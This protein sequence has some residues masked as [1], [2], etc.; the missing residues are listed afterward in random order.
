MAPLGA[1]ARYLNTL[2][3]QFSSAEALLR[4]KGDEKPDLVVGYGC[5]SVGTALYAKRRKLP[6]VHF[7]FGSL[8]DL[9]ATYEDEKR[10]W[11]IEAIGYTRR[12]EG[13][14]VRTLQFQAFLERRMA[15]RADMLIVPCNLRREEV[16]RNFHVPAERVAV[17]PMGVD[18]T[19]FQPT[20][21]PSVARAKLGL[22]PDAFVLLTIGQSIWRKGILYLFEA[23]R[24]ID[25]E[26]PANAKFLIAGF[27]QRE[28]VER[29]AAQRGIKDRVIC[30]GPQSHEEVRELYTAC[31]GF[32][33]PSVE[34]GFGLVILE[35]LAVG[36]PLV[37]TR[38][39]C[40]PDLLAD[41]ESALIVAQRDVRALGAAL[42]RLCRD[43]KLR[44][45]LR[46][47]GLRVARSCTWDLTGAKLHAVY[48]RVLD[49]RRSRIR[50]HG[51]VHTNEATIMS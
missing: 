8:F 29:Q 38:V 15:A 13:A 30:L 40:A 41:G 33:L 26:L 36:L 7:T 9:I 10:A 3:F 51:P 12:A 11:G 49:E 47:N 39:G 50:Q 23:I 45:S 5:D 25:R 17:V 32:V 2:V 44:E 48:E 14:M 27:H 24:E 22:A 21:S 18:V 31:D 43:S 6:F 20:V 34:E 35:A 42:L 46:S 4:L 37:V 28:L 19:A 16:I 1:L